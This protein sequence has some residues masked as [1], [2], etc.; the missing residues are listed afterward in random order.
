MDYVKIIEDIAKS[1]LLGFFI[2]V[3]IKT[4]FVKQRKTQRQKKQS[5]RMFLFE[6]F[7]INKETVLKYK[8]GLY[9]S[10][11]PEGNNS[12]LNI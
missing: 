2:G 3:L 4:N 6:K 10:L 12:F 8:K 11:N 5:L 7:N 9:C 1:V